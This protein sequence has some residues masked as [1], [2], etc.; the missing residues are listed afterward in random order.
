[1]PSSPKIAR[2]ATWPLLAAPLVMGAAL[3]AAV[4]STYRDVNTA[5]RLLV[6]GQAD[7]L[8]DDVRM[9]LFGA[10]RGGVLPDT[11]TLAGVLERLS[12]D[13]LRYVAVLDGDGHMVGEA[14]HAVGERA[15]LEAEVR[16][17]R[18]AEPVRLGEGRARV[19][20]RG[21]GRRRTP[22]RNPPQIVMEFEPKAAVALE[23]TAR[24][25]LLVGATA[26][27]LFFAAAA[28]LV[29]WLM[30]R[31]ASERRLEHERR[32][33]SLGR[34]SAVLAHEI[35]NPLAS[36]KGNAQLLAR[37][38]PEGDKPRAKADLVVN[39]AVRL[40]TL[41]NHLLEFARTGELHPTEIDPAAFVREV[42]QSF[43]VDRLDL[44]TSHAPARWRFD[45][46]RM[47]QVLANLVDNALQAGEG[48][49]DVGAFAGDGGKLVFSVRDRGGG[50]AEEDLA[51]IFEPFYTRRH[52]GTGLGLA[53]ARRFVELHGGTLTAAN[54]PGGG[55]V[56]TVVLPR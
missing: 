47:R 56:F 27:G 49:V 26:A 44:D 30:R 43:G 37:G 33:A 54:A 50:V 19:V 23:T 12:E 55:A 1:V 32:L 29:R 38:L 8:H 39:E 25:T 46:E 36:L 18:A 31:T 2:L 40:E 42:A 51:H 7:I 15:A 22:W 45:A 20:Y 13:G 5:S 17:M 28:A 21:P 6:R 14:G 10:G 53:V 48:R 41:A 24:R 16:G 52:Q 35:R 3:F 4:W 9:E 34:M 11:A